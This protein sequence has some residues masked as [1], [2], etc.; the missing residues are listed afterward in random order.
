MGDAS[1]YGCPYG[2]CYVCFWNRSE[3]GDLE[4]EVMAF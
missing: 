1:G 2:L 4:R 3:I